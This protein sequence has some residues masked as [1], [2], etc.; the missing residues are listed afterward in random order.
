VIEA[1]SANQ[2]QWMKKNDFAVSVITLKQKWTGYK[3]LAKRDISARLIIYNP[4]HK[5]YNYLP[6]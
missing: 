2:Q 5:R 4:F 6:F 3:R 1:V